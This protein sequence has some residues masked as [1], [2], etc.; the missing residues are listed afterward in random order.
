METQEIEVKT[1]FWREICPS[2][3]LHYSMK[4][5][6]GNKCI[7]KDFYNHYKKFYKQKLKEEQCPKQ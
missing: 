2:N 1:C 3:I 5:N 4:C 6:F 7:I